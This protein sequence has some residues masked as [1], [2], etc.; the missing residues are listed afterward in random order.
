[1][2]Q[3]RH[4]RTVDPGEGLRYLSTLRSRRN[5]DDKAQHGEVVLTLGGALM[6]AP[7]AVIERRDP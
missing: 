6:T 5:R 7:I 3:V 4:G 1:M 2:D